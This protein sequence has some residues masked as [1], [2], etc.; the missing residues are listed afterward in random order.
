MKN[1]PFHFSRALLSLG[2]VDIA[3]LSVL[4]PH[5]KSCIYKGDA[6]GRGKM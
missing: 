4:L 6:R 3:G 2:T 1:S 5:E